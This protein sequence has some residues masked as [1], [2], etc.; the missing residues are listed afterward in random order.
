ME[1]D[2]SI[3]FKQRKENV[4]ANSLSSQE[5][6][7]CKVIIT[8]TLESTMLNRITNNLQP[9]PDIQKL[10]HNLETNASSHKYY[11][12]WYSIYILSYLD[13]LHSFR[14]SFL[15]FYIINV[16]STLFRNFNSKLKMVQWF[17]LNAKN[18]IL[19]T[20]T[21]ANYFVHNFFHK[22]SI[23]FMF[24]TLDSRLK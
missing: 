12:W 20:L 5:V 18:F 17:S 14:L 10:F 24:T 9:D 11:T 2:F 21:I 15:L 3:E 8:L 16:V 1:F 7:D 6:I 13:S 22:F 23:E 4:V 19:A